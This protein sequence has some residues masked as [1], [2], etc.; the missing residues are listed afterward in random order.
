MR[1]L[2][3]AL[4]PGVIAQTG[5]FGIGTLLNL[6]LCMSGCLAVEA[7]VLRARG[8]PVAAL[9]AQLGDGS[10][11]LTGLLLGLALP[12]QGP[13]WLPLL[14]A[15]LAILI[16]KQLFGTRGN[17][18][19]NPAMAGLALLLLCVPQLMTRWLPV[20]DGVS[21]ATLLDQVRTGLH[22]ARTVDEILGHS[23]LHR[24]GEVWINLAFLAGGL[25]LLKRKQ[26]PWQIPL[27]V[28]A[29]LAVPA[30]IF[31][32]DDTS[33]HPSPLFHLLSGSTMLAAFFIATAPPSSPRL[34][35]TQLLY[36][37]GIGAAVYAIRSWG[38]YPDGVAFAV[39]LFNAAAPALDRWVAST[40]TASA[41]RFS[42][43][44]ATATLALAAGAMLIAQHI[45]Q[46][47]ANFVPALA[48]LGFADGSLRNAEAVEDARLGSF[49][50]YRIEQA[51][52]HAGLLLRTRAAGYAGDIDV[53]T[54][55][56]ADGRIAAVRVLHHDE[57]RGIGDRIDAGRDPWILGY[58]G[59][60]LDDT[61]IDQLSGATVS[62]RAV[63]S[64]VQ[65]ALEYDAAHRSTLSAP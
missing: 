31:W 27:G 44:L 58:A 36:G 2:W 41:R 20:I 8:H 48:E 60:S 28:M 37:L 49:R 16:G 61:R 5:I 25:W 42:W 33:R 6:V 59:K 11:L 55:I 12:A 64:A 24:H 54:A 32:A 18:P 26:V 38:A 1:V 35:K 57:T 63:G 46:R 56:R 62:A 29:G 45:E 9:R 14:G 43:P 47:R 30:L 7:A 4:L 65:R 51:G 19:Y 40:A 22:L 53:L 34:A 23:G 17:S 3:L 21:S 13:W 15:A 39:L 50:R 52:A 10:T